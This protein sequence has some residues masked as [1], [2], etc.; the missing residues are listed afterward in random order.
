MTNTP[1]NQAPKPRERWIDV[2]KGIAIILVVFFHATFDY[3]ADAHVWQWGNY[4]ELL[5]TFRMP[6]FFFTAGIFAASA[7]SK[8]FRELL[9][10]RVLRFV[11]LYLLWSTI[12]VFVFWLLLGEKLHLGNPLLELAL[13][14]VIPNS[15]TW[16]IY[17]IAVYFVVGW[18]IR[19]LPLAVQLGIALVLTI[20]FQSGIITDPYSEWGKV[21]KYFLFFLLA[22]EF[23]PWVRRLVPRLRWWHTLIGPTLYA[24][25]VYVFRRLDWLDAPIGSAK[26][27]I[28]WTVLSVLAVVAGCSVAVLVARWAA[29]DWLFH[30]GSRTL[31]VYLLHWY[32]LLLGWWLASVIPVP[33]P[34]EPWLVPALTAFAISGSLLVHHFTKRATFLYA[35]P[36]WFRVPVRMSASDVPR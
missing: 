23:G 14:V 30:L 20:V 1:V 21:G 32:L 17:A 2:A 13:E 6:L 7:L 28:A 22:V 24:L 25:L 9:N 33:G 8:P 35:R 10:M 11:W 29:F 3:V 26:E 16:F 5:E 36:E 31:Q 4:T 34:I 15:Q 19:K 27:L 12:A 18:A